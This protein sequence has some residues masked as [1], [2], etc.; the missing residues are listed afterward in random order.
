MYPLLFQLQPPHCAWV[1]VLLCTDLVLCETF[2]VS[3]DTRATRV[4]YLL[5]FVLTDSGRLAARS[6]SQLNTCLDMSLSQHVFI[7][8]THSI[9]RPEQYEP[10]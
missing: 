9:H 5:T 4:S 6:C 1:H 10:A 8:Q 7:Q 3:G 2:E